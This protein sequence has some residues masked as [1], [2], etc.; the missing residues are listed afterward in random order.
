[1]SQILEIFDLDGNPLGF[2]NREQ[3][4]QEIEEEYSLTNKITKQV[5]T[6]SSL[7]LNPQGRMLLQKRGAFKKYN[8]NLFDKTVGRHKITNLSTDISLIIGSLEE[9]QIPGT[10]V[11]DEEFKETLKYTNLQN[12][13]IYKKISPPIQRYSIREKKDGSKIIQPQLTTYYLGIYRGSFCANLTNELSGI[14]TY[15][16]DELINEIEKSPE[17][18][19]QDLKDSIPL[20]ISQ[21]AFKNYF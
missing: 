21:N 19:T 2:E 14:K 17:E 8:S 3:Y 13:C 5:Q 12:I 11:E 15:S 4:Y 16:L 9:F 6:I 10:V 20:Y 18:F 1:M 7:I